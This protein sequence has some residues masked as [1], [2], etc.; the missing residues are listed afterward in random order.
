MESPTPPCRFCGTFF[1]KRLR[2]CYNSHLVAFVCVECIQRLG[3][4][5]GKAEIQRLLD[6]LPY[7]I[8]KS[9]LREKILATQITG[10][11]NNEE[12]YFLRATIH[13]QKPK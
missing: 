5:Q 7:P 6:L 12:V 2:F 11:A 9:N 8:E 10:A 1:R 13:S 3:K 4:N